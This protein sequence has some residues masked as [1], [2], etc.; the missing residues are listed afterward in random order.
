MSRH[1]KNIVMSGLKNIISSYVPSPAVSTPPARGVRYFRPVHTF[2]FFWGA[3]NDLKLGRK[4]RKHII[5]RRYPHMGNRLLQLYTYH[6][7]THWSDACVAN[8]ELIKIAQR[9]AHALE[10]DYSPVGIEWRIRFFKHYFTV[11]KGGATPEP[12]LKPYSRFYQYTYVA[13]YRELQAARQSALSA[14]QSDSSALTPDD[15]TF[16]PIEQRPL[17]ADIIR[18]PSF[19]H[20]IIPSFHHSFIT[21]VRPVSTRRTSLLLSRQTK[22]SRKNLHICKF[23]RNFAPDFDLKNQMNK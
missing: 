20:Y 23:F 7:P 14:S 12:G 13:I 3:M 6:F 2:Q 10:H 5:V 22:K 21:S 15:V 18:R 19:H 4:R 16:D 11:V 1:L 8:R 9:Q 17:Q